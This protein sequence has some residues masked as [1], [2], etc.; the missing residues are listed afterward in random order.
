MRGDHAITPI[1]LDSPQQNAAPISTANKQPNTNSNCGT[2]TNTV[3][4][5]ML[6]QTSTAPQMMPHVNMQAKKRNNKSPLAID[7]R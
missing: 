7:L 5:A 2:Q 1:N 3:P 6:R 4:I